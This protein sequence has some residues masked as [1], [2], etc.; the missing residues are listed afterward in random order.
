MKLIRLLVILGATSFFLEARYHKI[1]R[2]SELD[3]LVDGYE[4]SVV[5]FAPATSLSDEYLD[6]DELK[7]RKKKF[8]GIEDILRSISKSRD[9]KN[10]LSKDVGFI[11]VDVAGKYAHDAIAEYGLVQ[12]PSCFVFDQGENT[13]QKVV[14]PSSSKDLTRLLER[15]GGADFKRLLAE[16][17]AESSQERQ[18]RIALY[19]SYGGYP[20]GYNWGYGYYGGPYGYGPYWGWYGCW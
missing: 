9:Y 19:Y 20:Y 18:E 7:D 8:R 17:K 15:V 1:T 14:R 16:R 3:K 4:Y 13:G 10:F 2:M 5:C 11:A 12:M 6:R